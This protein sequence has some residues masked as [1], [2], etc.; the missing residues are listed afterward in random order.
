MKDLYTILTA[1]FGWT[2][3]V[4]FILAF[5]K[6]L[7]ELFSTPVVSVPYP[8]DPDPPSVLTDQDREAIAAYFYKFDARKAQEPDRPWAVRDNVR[9]FQKRVS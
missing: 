8:H 1:P 4:V 5:G 9:P 2:L 3:L 6:F 7:Y